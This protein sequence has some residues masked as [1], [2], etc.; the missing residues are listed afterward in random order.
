MVLA[1]ASGSS[2]RLAIHRILP[3]HRPSHCRRPHRR[4]D[5]G[6]APKL[7]TWCCS[8]RATPPGS[9]S[10]PLIGESL[11]TS[12]P[13]L[14]MRL[15]SFTPVQVSYVWNEF[16]TFVPI[17]NGRRAGRLSKG[18]LLFHSAYLVPVS[19]PCKKALRS[20]YVLAA[21]TRYTCPPFGCQSEMRGGE[22]I[23]IYPAR[24]LTYPDE[25]WSSFAGYTY[26][27]VS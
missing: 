16:C 13:T 25:S 26:P 22:A 5:C 7:R 3:Q 23:K 10:A 27:D 17:E 21:F 19:L 14:W 20:V 4:T 2:R 1:V 15:G 12:A 8:W 24:I 9:P 18:G 11:A 6:G